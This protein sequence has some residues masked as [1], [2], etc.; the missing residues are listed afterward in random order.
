M[1]ESLNSKNEE[2]RTLRF[3][4]WINIGKKRTFEKNSWEV[5]L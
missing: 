3:Q 1:L 2:S 5:Q 4:A